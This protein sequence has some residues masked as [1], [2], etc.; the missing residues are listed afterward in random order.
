MGSLS[1]LTK[2]EI[3]KKYA[4]EYAAA[5]KKARGRMLDEL[6]ATTGWSRANARR[7]VTAAGK[8]RG[9]QRAAKRALRARTYGYDTLKLLIRVWM[10]AGQPS[11]KWKVSGAGGTGGSRVATP[12]RDRVRW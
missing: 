1:M 8:R 4:R 6:V 2:R 12:L 3:T 9:P 7:Q 11:G 10:L 5:S